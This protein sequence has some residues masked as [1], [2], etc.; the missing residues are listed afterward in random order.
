MFSPGRIQSE[1][2]LTL[3][4]T[5]ASSVWPAGTVKNYVQLFFP[6]S[7][8]VDSVNVGHLVSTR[9]G[10]SVISLNIDIPPG[11]G[12]DIFIKYHQQLP[13]SQPHYRFTYLPQ[14]GLLSFSFTHTLTFPQNWSVTA[15]QSPEVAQHGRLRYNSQIPNPY[16]LDL[17][18][19]Q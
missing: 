12:R 6:P 17:D 3:V 1:Y 4:N 15:H 16:V 14:P 10:F 19:T 18:I 9:P 13:S 5:S 11:E 7:I 2:R 8:V